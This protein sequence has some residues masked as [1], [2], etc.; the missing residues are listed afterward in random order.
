MSDCIANGTKIPR[1]QTGS[2]RSLIATILLREI[3]VAPCGAGGTLPSN[4]LCSSDGNVRCTLTLS[5]E[6][7]YGMNRNLVP[8]ELHEGFLSF[9]L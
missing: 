5:V 8:S 4:S 9:G 6:E 7:K 3:A 1:L 2:F